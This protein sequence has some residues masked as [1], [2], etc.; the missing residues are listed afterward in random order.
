MFYC[1]VRF[2]V[3]RL[4]KNLATLSMYNLNCNKPFFFNKFNLAFLSKDLIFFE[5]IISNS[6]ATNNFK[7]VLERLQTC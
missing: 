7:S 2:V 5:L 1:Q 4:H 6:P 3:Q